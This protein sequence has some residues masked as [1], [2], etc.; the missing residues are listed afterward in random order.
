LA[1]GQVPG[2]RLGQLLFESALQRPVQVQVQALRSLQ[3][4]Q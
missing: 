4:W 2:L 3:Q 1:Q